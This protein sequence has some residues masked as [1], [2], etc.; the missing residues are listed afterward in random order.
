[1]SK[2][3]SRAR[4]LAGA[5][6]LSL[7]PAAGTAAARSG[8]G[9]TYRGVDYEVTDGET[10]ATGWNAARMRADLRA[11][12]EDLHANS[13][14]VYGTGVERLAATAREAA[15]RGLHV[16]LQPRLADVAEEDILDHLAET[17]REAERLRRDGARVN[18]AVG[19]EFWLF[20]PGI[21]PGDQALE[22]VENMLAGTYDVDRMTRLLAAFTARAA[23]VGRSVFRGPLTYGAAHDPVVDR[24]DWS[25]FDIV[26]LDYYALHPDAAGHARE[27]AE[28]R[29]WGKPL[30]ILECG[31]CAYTGAPEAGGMAWRFT[32][33]SELE[34]NEAAQAA[35]VGQMIDVFTSL[36]LHTALIHQFTTPDAPHRTDP[37]RD[38]DKAAYG[39][40]KTIWHNDTDP[41]TGHHWE[42][43]QAFH[44]AAHHFATARSH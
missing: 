39:L 8:G 20:V 19:C 25:L 42:P 9:L 5:A 43:K 31:T 41:A 16:W 17:G 6:A 30:A 37:S 18:L 44:T 2:G 13:V 34:R 21:V 26:G 22:R 7:A 10:P 40:V 27:L 33:L 23:R 4:F 11:V 24:V 15:E 14:M 29:R 35:Y 32:D 1:M 12:A 28:Y 36:N 3:M 38:E